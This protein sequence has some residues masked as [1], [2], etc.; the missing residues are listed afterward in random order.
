MSIAFPPLLT[1][2]AVSDDP[3][4]AA[5]VAADTADPGT[6]FYGLD[7]EVMRTAMASVVE[8]VPIV[9]EAAIV[10]SWGDAK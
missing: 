4:E 5:L 7:P 8:G 1:G 9:V 6:V 10:S 3:L 2:V